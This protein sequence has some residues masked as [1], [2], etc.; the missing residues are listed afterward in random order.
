MT[1]LAELKIYGLNERYENSLIHALGIMRNVYDKILH[2][3]DRWH[4]FWEG[5]YTVIRCDPQYVLVVEQMLEEYEDFR[6]ER[7]VLGYMEN[8]TTTARYLD[9]FISIFHGFSVLAMDMDDEYF[10]EVFERI[11]HCFLNVMTRDSIKKHFKIHGDVAETHCGMG[12]EGLAIQAIAHMR[13][14]TAGWYNK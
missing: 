9:A 10:I 7:A 14:Y 6:C 13:S 1:Q 12:W 8:V 3:D 11:N 4:F 2:N 5:A